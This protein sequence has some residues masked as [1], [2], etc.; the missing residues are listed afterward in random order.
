MVKK[1]LKSMDY[2]VIVIAVFLFVIGII[3][4]FSANGG[5]E[6]DFSETM[7][8]VAWFGMG[9]GLMTLL[10]FVDY[11]A[12]LGKLWIPLY[13]LSILLLVGVLFTEPVNGAT[14]WFHL[15]GMSFQPSEFAKIVLILSVAKA[16]CF[17]K[18]K[19]KLNSPLAILAIL[20][21][22]AVPVLLVI[23]QPDYGTAMVMLV[24]VGFMLFLSGIDY[25]YVLAAILLVVV[26]LPLAYQYVLPEHAKS[27]IMVFLNPQTDPQGAGYN[28]IQAELAV[29]FWAAMGNGTARGKSDTATDIY[30]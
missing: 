19:G 26:A 10:A 11:E 25:R 12:I 8:Q 22:M 14:S 17:F 1:I 5:F 4:L 13:V 29:R 23:K 27:R 21:L 9:M 3:A 18:D 24:M 30:R 15:G 2:S 16:I 6:G 28:I 7:K 20:L